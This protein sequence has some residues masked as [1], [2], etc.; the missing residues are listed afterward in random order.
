LHAFGVAG[1]TVFAEDTDESTN[2]KRINRV[3]GVAALLTPD[4]GWQ[5]DAKLFDAYSGATRHDKVTEF[6]QENQD[7]ENRDD[8]ERIE[9]TAHA[10]VASFLI[11]RPSE[12]RRSPLNL[13]DANVNPTYPT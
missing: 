11:L 5:A 2:R 3:E 9:K 10:R 7:G 8:P 6:V 13:C 12:R 4:A 1:L